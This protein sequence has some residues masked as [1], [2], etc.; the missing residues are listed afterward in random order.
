MDINLTHKLK[1]PVVL[2]THPI[3]V[4]A[5]G[6]QPLSSVTHHSTGLVSLFTSDNHTE[7]IHF[8]VN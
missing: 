7:E 1:I 2:L 8:F 6:G 3:S 5:L 4:N